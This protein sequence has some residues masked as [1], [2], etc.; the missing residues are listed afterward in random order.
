MRIVV[1]ANIVFSA[2]LNTES[3]IGQALLNPLQDVQFVAPEYLL[4]EI[5][6]HHSKI[7]S[8]TGFSSERV[9]DIQHLIC[10]HILFISEAQIPL[11][12]LERAEKLVSDID[13][14]DALYVALSDFFHC[15]IWS[16]DLKLKDGLTNKEFDR[17][18]AI[19]ELLRSK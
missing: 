19:E 16:G 13:P 14:K 9:M 6:L 11:D 15:P 17:F 1:D 4:H 12:M 3:R 7:C 2:I 18:I 5:H 8:I 10:S